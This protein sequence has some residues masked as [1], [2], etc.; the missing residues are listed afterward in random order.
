MQAEY[1]EFDNFRWINCNWWSK[2]KEVDSLVAELVQEFPSRKRD[3]YRINMKVLVLTLYQSYLCDPEQYLAYSRDKNDYNFTGKD[4]PYIKNS[5]VSYTYLVESVDLLTAKG[6]LRNRKGGQFFNPETNTLHS[7]VSRMRPL[8]PFMDLVGRLGVRPEMIDT[9]IEDDVLILRGEPVEEVYEYR[10][11][12]RTRLVKPSLPVPK[13]A[14]TISMRRVIRNYSSLLQR[15]HIDVDVECMTAKDR[16]ETVEKLADMALPGRR[17]R[18]VLRLS[19]KTVYRVFNNGSMKQGGRFYGAWWIGAPS[20][21]RKYITINGDPTV[22]LD[23]SAMHIHLLYAKVGIN[24]ADK[25]EDAYTLDDGLDS[26]NDAD[27]DRDLN[28]LILLTAFNAKTPQLAASAVFDELRDQCKLYRYRIKGHKPIKAKL[29]LLKQKHPLIAHLIANDQGRDLQYYDSCIIEKV[30]E[31]FTKKQIPVLTVHDSVICQERHM[32]TVTNVMYR[33]FYQ[34][35]EDH[36]NISVTPTPKYKWAGVITQQLNKINPYRALT[37]W[38]QAAKKLGPLIK[39]E[40][41]GQVSDTIPNTLKIKTTNRANRCNTKC[42]HY[43]RLGKQLKYMPN[44]KLELKHES[45]TF[46]NVLVVR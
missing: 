34:I 15:T 13:N 23:F 11:K 42:N 20:I 26:L 4:H 41:Q 18:I 22:E 3:G 31:Y 1:T 33:Y 35:S 29:E 44:V 28:K 9:L 19:K 45:E 25:G 30:I 27:D 24:Y 40:Y 43:I 21:V 38:W 17:K 6:F 2:A 46:T 39:P 12:V 5:K 37:G 14:A 7:Y 8:Q 16:D 10:G 36:L 32:E